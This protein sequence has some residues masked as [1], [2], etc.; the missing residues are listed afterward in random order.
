MEKLMTRLETDYEV[1]VIDAPPLL[2][3]TDPAVLGSM[4]SGVVL[5]VSADGRTNRAELAQAVANLEAVD[6]RLLGLV[7]NRLEKS[8]SSHSYYDYRPEFVESGKR[9]NLRTKPSS[10]TS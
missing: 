6:A 2:P 10:F 5:V 1:V 3:V 7:V 4:A 8:A 9:G